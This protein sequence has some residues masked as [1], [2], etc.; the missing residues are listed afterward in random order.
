M[1]EPV[2]DLFGFRKPRPPRRVM[3][4]A[5]DVGQAPGL[6]P[7]WRTTR[8]G[9]FVCPRCGHDAEW[10][11]DLTETEIRAGVACPICNPQPAEVAHAHLS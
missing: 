4:R 3:I 10:R 6:K 9:H 1:A 11:F 5:A 8:G 7:G 2:L